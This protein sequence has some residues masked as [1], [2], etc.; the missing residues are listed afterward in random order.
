MQTAVKPEPESNGVGVGQMMITVL[1]VFCLEVLPQ[2]P[3]V[4]SCCLAVEAEMSLLLL[5]NVCQSNRKEP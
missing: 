3:S 5:L 4:M 2:L 1:C